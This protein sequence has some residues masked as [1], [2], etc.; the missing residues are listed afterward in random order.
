MQYEIDS[1][2]SKIWRKNL[3]RDDRCI[4]SHL[5]EARY[6]F[7]DEKFQLFVNSI[8]LWL[9]L[10]IYLFLFYL[11]LLLFIFI[12]IFLFIFIFIFIYFLF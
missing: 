11:F 2:L 7:L 8:P 9:F 1:D 4:S 10:F 3:G 6:P 12:I 5:I